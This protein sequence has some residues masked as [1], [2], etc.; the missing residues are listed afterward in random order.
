METKLAPSMSRQSSTSCHSFGG[1]A[2]SPR[3][4]PGWGGPV[5]ISFPHPKLV[6]TPPFRKKKTTG[7][8]QLCFVASRRLVGLEQGC[9]RTLKPS[10]RRQT[11]RESPPPLLQPLGEVSATPLRS[12]LA[13]A[14]QRSASQHGRPGR[15]NAE[16]EAQRLPYPTLSGCARWDD[17]TIFTSYY[18]GLAVAPR[19][20]HTCIHSFC[21]VGLCESVVQS[22]SNLCPWML[23]E[24][25]CTKNH[26]IYQ[27]RPYFQ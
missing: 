9:M 24:S 11:F 7:I 18:I 23:T 1:N 16:A 17:K 8:G 6:K 14:L 15:P 4:P 27:E 12:A 20:A 3:I 13:Q 26:H 22:T 5:C 2:G 10:L 25:E 19:Q 21:L